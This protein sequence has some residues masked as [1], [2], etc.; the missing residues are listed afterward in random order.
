MDVNADKELLLAPREKLDNRRRRNRFVVTSRSIPCLPIRSAKI[1]AISPIPFRM[2]AAGILITI[3]DLNI[4]LKRGRLSVPPNDFYLTRLI[5]TKF[6]DFLAFAASHVICMHCD[7]S[8]SN[9]E[10]CD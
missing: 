8:Q 9:G 10:H 5:F 7:S 3:G 4:N 1:G 2:G 6:S